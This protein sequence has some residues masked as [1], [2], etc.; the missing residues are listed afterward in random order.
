[1]L[2]IYF[3]LCWVLGCCFWTFSSCSER[4]LLFVAMHWLFIVEASFAEEH[5]GFPGGTVVK[6]PPANAGDWG[7]I[8]ELGKSPGPGNGLQNSCRRNPMDGRAWWATVYGVAKRQTTDTNTHTHT[9][10]HTHIHTE[11][12]GHEASVVVAHRLHSCGAWA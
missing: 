1:M 7:L 10:T 11:V 6:N 8:P 9:H 4:G 5:R 3:C 2:C 12:L